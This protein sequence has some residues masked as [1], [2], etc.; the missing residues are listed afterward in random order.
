[1]K[2]TIGAKLWLSYLAILLVIFFVA[3]MA[4]RN[5]ARA[6]ESAYWVAHTYQVTIK[7]N[8]LFSSIQDAETGTRGY[9]ITGSERYLAPYLSGTARIPGQLQS[10]RQ[11]TASNA[12]QQRRLDK[13]EPLINQKLAVMQKSITLRR[14]QG[15]EGV[16]GLVQTGAGK[17]AMD[18][19]RTQVGDMIHEENTLQ[20]V[21]DEAAAQAAKRSM[22][23]ILLGVAVSGVIVVA[24]GLF[25]TAHIA[26]PVRDMADISERISNGD[27]SCEP[28]LTHRQDEIGKLTEHFRR[29][30]ASLRSK[31][32]LAR[33][34]AG[35][36][37]TVKLEQHSDE[38]ILGVALAQMVQNLRQFNGEIRAG[39]DMLAASSGEIA[40]GAVQIASATEETATS[41]IETAT[42]AEEVKQA[43]MLASQQARTLSTSS[44]EAAMVSQEGK[45]AVD[46]TVASMLQAHKQAELISEC[47]LRLTEQTQAI[48][49]IVATVNDLAE[50]SNVL[51]VNASLEAAKAGDY[52]LGFAMVAQEVKG[53]A[54]QSKKATVNV[55][56]ILGDI[57]RAINRASFA[58]EQGSR[59]AESGLKQST[60]A[61]DAIRFL[62]ERLSASTQVA[63]QIAV[64]SQQQLVGIEQLVVAMGNIH[65]VSAQ[66]MASSRQAGSASEQLHRLGLQLKELSSHFRI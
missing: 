49:E 36:D 18:G 40:A 17:T 64:S 48:A 63:T 50:Q 65:R 12:N 44:Q 60:Q 26:R 35:G 33:Q 16:L 14:E 5:Q 9:A 58:A 34:I 11:L 61:G 39:I 54:N 51:A 55:T 10:V 28:A 45:Q 1:M 8:E 7:L 47:V 4:Y 27:L 31:A 38:D 13:L 2:A 32:E 21:R 24:L 37:L 30:V 19:I 3:A 52:G 43:A 66:N 25:F 29:M 22:D 42:S 59:A 46:E 62:S 15:F 41:V 56:Q 6:N 23:S 53:L 57:Q 20:Q